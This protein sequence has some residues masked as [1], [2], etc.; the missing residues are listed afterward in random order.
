MRT[1]EKQENRHSR[2]KCRFRGPL[3]DRQD[4]TSS[5]W[6]AVGSKMGFPGA[7][8]EGPGATQEA[9][10][11]PKSGGLRAAQEAPGALGEAFW[12]PRGWMLAPPVLHYR[13]F[14]RLLRRLPE[15]KRKRKSASA[16]ASA[17]RKRRGLRA[18]DSR[19]QGR[20]AS[21]TRGPGGM[22][23]AP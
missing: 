10:D 3:H 22:C 18:K 1:P 8:K 14:Q 15:S 17:Q 23:G 13:S 4:W 7:A 6:G 20:Q 2:R 5:L 12:P 16:G 9:Q 11:D 21:R 19:Q